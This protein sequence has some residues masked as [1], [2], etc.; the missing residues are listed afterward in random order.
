VDLVDAIDRIEAAW[1]GAIDPAYMRDLDADMT[2]D[3]DQFPVEG[4]FELALCLLGETSAEYGEGSIYLAES[5]VKLATL[6][7]HVLPDKDIFQAWL[8]PTVRR[9]AQI[10]PRTADYDRSSGIYDASHEKPVPREFFDPSFHYDD[11]A[12]AAAIR[13]FLKSLDP[14]RNPY[15]SSADEMKAAGFAGTPYNY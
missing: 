3:D 2:H 11:A 9:L 10:F 6:A 13:Q 1:A 12:A 5:V 15:L 7:A 8:S 4:A 14:R